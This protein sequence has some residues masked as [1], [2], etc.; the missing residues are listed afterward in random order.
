M[1]YCKYYFCSTL[2][3]KNTAYIDQE[4]TIFP[5][6]QKV[7]FRH[8]YILNVECEIE[9]FIYEGWIVFVIS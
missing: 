2:C 5:V 6:V 7:D 1:T 4:M 8:K 3:N 9:K